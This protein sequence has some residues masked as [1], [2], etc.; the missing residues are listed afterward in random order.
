MHTWRNQNKVI[1]KKING[2]SNQIWKK[3]WKLRENWNRKR[4]DEIEIEVEEMTL[5]SSSMAEMRSERRSKQRSGSG[6]LWANEETIDSSCATSTPNRDS[7]ADA[8]WIFDMW[9]STST[10]RWC[11]LEYLS[12]YNVMWLIDVFKARR[13]R[14]RTC[15]DHRLMCKF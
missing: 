1:N 11:I 5:V 7:G 2:T 6:D 9:I 14:R 10:F 12:R 15:L 4:C 13:R 8:I 3:Q